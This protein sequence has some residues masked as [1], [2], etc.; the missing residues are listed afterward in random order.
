MARERGLPLAEDKEE[1]IVLHSKA[2]RRGR[3]GVAEKA[4]RLGV[5]FDD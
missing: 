1:R 2:G 5:I 4:K 3:R